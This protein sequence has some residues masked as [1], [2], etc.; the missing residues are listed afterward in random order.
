MNAFKDICH[1]TQAFRRL[2]SIT[3]TIDFHAPVGDWTRDICS[4]LE[5]APLEVFQLYATGASDDVSIPDYFWRS[6][7]A[8]H[9]PRLK[10]FSVLRMQMSPTALGII[11]LQ[12]IQLERLFVLVDQRDLVSTTIHS[13]MKL[14]IILVQIVVAQLLALAENLRTLHINI[15]VD[16]LSSPKDTAIFLASYCSSTLTHVGCNTQVWQASWKTGHS[17]LL[18]QLG[19]NQ[20][21]RNVCVDGNGEKYT[22]PTLIPQE[23]PEIPEQFLVV[24]A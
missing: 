17:R 15:A 10:C 4:L 13:T 18:M 12:C 23:N 6:V 11:C 21:Q 24:R 7:T 1:R 14:L 5:A 3:L 22:L 19:S 9:G 2:R 16:S 20:V 8:T